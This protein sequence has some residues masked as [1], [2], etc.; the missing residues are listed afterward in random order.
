ME[1]VPDGGLQH[2]VIA[3]VAFF[4]YCCNG[5]RSL[6]RESISGHPWI[7]LVHVKDLQAKRANHH[8]V[9]IGIVPHQDFAGKCVAPWLILLEEDV[10]ALV[11]DCVNSLQAVG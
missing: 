6:L 3:K 7:S 8:F 1:N 10:G 11:K 5:R 4:P 9:L 2:E